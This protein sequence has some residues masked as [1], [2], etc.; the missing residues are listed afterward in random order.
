[1]TLD[2]WIAPEGRAKIYA[3]LAAIGAVLTG[4]GI[5]RD[6]VLQ[7]WLGVANAI[8]GVAA[9]L[10]AS[11]HAQRF[12][13]VATYTALAVLVAGLQGVGLLDLTTATRATTIL[14][15]ITQ[16]LGLV[17]ARARTDASTPTGEPAAEYDARHAA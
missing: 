1:M 15:A 4:L 6:D 7:G 17:L 13:M 12:D 10:V 8:L 2:D 14:S 5:V 3:T 16:V 9:L 11:W